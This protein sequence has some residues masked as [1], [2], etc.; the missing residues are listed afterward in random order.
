MFEGYLKQSTQ[1]TVTVLMISSTDHIA[2]KTGLSAGL[3]IYA[4]KAGA[5]PAAI[6]PTVAELDATNMPGLYS[7]IF[8]TAHTNTLGEF[9]IRVSGSGADPTDVKWQVTARLNDDLAYPATSGRSMVVDA[10][11]LVDANAVKLGPSGSGT[12]QTA[13]D[14]GA[15]IPAAAPG[16][17]GGLFIAGSNAAT[18]VTTAFTA[19]IVGNLSGS[20]ASVTGAVG[21]V[22]AGVTVTT[23]NDKTGYSLSVTPPTAAQNATALLTDLLAS[24]DFNTASSFGKLIKDNLN[25]PVGSIPTNPYTGTPPTVAQ[26]R[27]EIDTNSTQLIAIKAKTD[28]IATN[29]GDSPNDVTM[30]GRI[31]GTVM[32]A[33]G[34]T[35]PTAKNVLDKIAAQ[36]AVYGIGTLAEDASSGQALVKLG[37]SFGA[38]DVGKRLVVGNDDMILQSYSAISGFT[39][40]TNFTQNHTSGDAFTVYWGKRVIDGTKAVPT[41]GNTANTIDDCLNGARAQGFGPWA[42][43]GLNLN[44]YASD[45]ITVVHSFLL[46]SA[47][48]PTSRS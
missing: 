14:V 8:T 21:S 16:A 7:L 30:Q 47:T 20:V 28:L 4:T 2:G 42:I 5:A 45:G 33:S 15:A 48:A 37:G 18:S 35:A 31:T 41:T 1:V 3:T 36:P 26:I 11:G 43:V 12:A 39:C 27:T 9:A 10:A 46:D 17:A 25:A 24:S 29:A 22:T 40:S 6:T 44:L 32:L 19:N 38:G 34:Y 13:R 23:N